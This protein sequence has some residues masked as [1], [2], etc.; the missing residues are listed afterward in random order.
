MKY[1]ADAYWKGKINEQK[2]VD[3]IRWERKR[4]LLRFTD[5][6]ARKVAGISG[7]SIGDKVI[8]DCQPNRIVIEK[9]N[10]LEEEK[11]K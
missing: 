2:K 3:C 5:Y 1:S 11:T 4:L 8:I 6:P 7:F 10:P 9:E